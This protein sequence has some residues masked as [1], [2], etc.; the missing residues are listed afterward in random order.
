MLR[1]FGAD[2]PAMLAVAAILLGTLS[3]AGSHT[4]TSTAHLS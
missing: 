4:P 1:K 3:S 2:Y